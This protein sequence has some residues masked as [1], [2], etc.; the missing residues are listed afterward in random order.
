MSYEVLENSVQ[1]G[2]PIY[3][4][5]FNIDGTEYRLT[6]ASFFISDSVDTWTPSAI[7]ATNVT[8]SND[9]ARNGISI[10][11]PRTE[12]VAG[13][14]L[15]GVPSGPSTLTIF[16]G[17]SESDQSDFRTYW[18]GRVASVE[19]TDQSVVLKCEDVFTS[20]RRPGA[21]ARYQRSCRHALYSPQCGVD[22]ADYAVAVTVRAQ[23]GRTLTIDEA[24]DSD[25]ETY[26]GPSLTGGIIELETGERRWITFGGSTIIDVL[27]PFQGLEFDSNGVGAVLYPGCAKTINSC[28]NRFDNFLNFGGFP[29]IPED[30]PFSSSITGS[31]V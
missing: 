28:K 16:R 5:L 14:F 11:L 18:K 12:G 23:T 27:Y 8:Q 3:K 30:N 29:F 15:G 6:S 9:L 22:P 17:H 4:F 31:I 20:M 2:E 13:E 25:G 1:D 24:L 10:T 7:R 26:D 21:R 19:T